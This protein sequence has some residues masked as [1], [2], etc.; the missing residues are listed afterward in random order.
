MTIERAYVSCYL[1][2]PCDWNIDF[3]IIIYLAEKEASY[4]CSTVE[5]SG[6]K[7]LTSP[8]FTNLSETYLYTKQ[9]DE[10]ITVVIQ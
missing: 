10:Q 4:G 3:K 9:V 2:A 7:L 5:S 8:Q 1:R 6:A